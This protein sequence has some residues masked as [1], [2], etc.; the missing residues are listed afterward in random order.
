MCH[1]GKNVVLETRGKDQRIS[2]EFLDFIRLS[3]CMVTDFCQRDGI[4]MVQDR[5]TKLHRHVAEIE[6]TV[7]FVHVL[8]NVMR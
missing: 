4:A 7:E 1:N 8:S 6:K 5:D 2:L 3:V